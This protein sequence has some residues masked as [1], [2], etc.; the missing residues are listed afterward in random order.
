MWILYSILAALFS[1]LSIFFSK[2][3]VKNIDVI[4]ATFLRTIIILLFSLIIVIFNSSFNEII[5][6]KS[7]TYFYLLL[8]G[9]S[10]TILWLSYFKAL[11]LGTINK[12]TP[13]DKTSIIITLLLSFILLKER[14]NLI[15]V[16]G[17]FSILFGTIL[18]VCKDKKKDKNSKW[19]LY[20]IIASVFSSIATIVGKIGLKN[21][22][23][24]LGMLLRNIVIF[25]IIII[26][27]TFKKKY[28]YISKI[29]K[30]E[31]LFLIISGLLTGLSWM[32]Y[33]KALKIGKAS[34]VFS[35]EKLSIVIAIIASIIFLKEKMNFKSI[36]GLII[37]ILG[38]LFLVS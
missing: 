9:V 1:G 5:N 28:K 34:I 20:A 33:F 11:Q 26:I 17:M 30:K 8:S 19:L 13:V 21:I 38:E 32:F 10:T 4:I 6:V 15:K 12:V 31:L 2:I 29:N 27:L 24:N 35:I 18:M 36:I 25:V 22:D 14:I 7:D 37:I 16:I 23:S 3:G